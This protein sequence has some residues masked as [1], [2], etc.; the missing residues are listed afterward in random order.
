MIRLRL[1]ARLRMGALL[2]LAFVTSG[3]LAGCG[4]EPVTS[5]AFE[6]WA[7][8]WLSGDQT[9]TGRVPREEW[10]AKNLRPERAKIA[11]AMQ[12]MDGQ[13]G[14]WTKVRRHGVASVRTFA[15]ASAAELRGTPF[16]SKERAEVFGHLLNS[17]KLYA[18]S[19]TLKDD[20]TTERIYWFVEVGDRFQHIGPM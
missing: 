20:G 8:R 11:S 2:A 10:I 13:G 15:F 19:V 7:Q 9:A 17:V 18:L 12:H 5:S 14:M 6:A 4:Q 16:D 3:M 1:R